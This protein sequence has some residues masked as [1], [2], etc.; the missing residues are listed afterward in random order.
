MRKSFIHFSCFYFFTCRSS[1]DTN[2]QTRSDDHNHLWVKIRTIVSPKKVFTFRD[3]VKNQENHAK[4][5]YLPGKFLRAL[6]FLV[7]LSFKKCPSPFK[8]TQGNHLSGQCLRSFGV[9]Q[10]NDDYLS[11]Y[12]YHFYFIFISVG[13]VFCKVFQGKQNKTF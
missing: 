10:D 13:C 2:T 4:A 5:D 11:L 6:Y 1:V 7:L 8:Q 9:W 12:Y 3:F